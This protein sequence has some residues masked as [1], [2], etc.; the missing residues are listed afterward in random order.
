VVAS[1][2]LLP[3]EESVVPPQAASMEM[4]KPV[5]RPLIMVRFMLS[6]I[7]VNGVKTCRAVFS[8]GDIDIVASMFNVPQDELETELL[9]LV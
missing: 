5:I 9:Y 4:D 6:P 2:L 7:S 8:R 3:E 1:I